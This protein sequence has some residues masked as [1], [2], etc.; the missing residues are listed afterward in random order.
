MFDIHRSRYTMGYANSAMVARGF[1][2]GKGLRS[3]TALF[4]RAN[5]FVFHS[6][7]SELL[8]GVI[9]DMGSA[10]DFI[11]DARCDQRLQYASVRLKIRLR[12]IN[13]DQYEQFCGDVF[14]VL[15]TYI[16]SITTLYVD[17]RFTRQQ[18]S[19]EAFLQSLNNFACMQQHL[20]SSMTDQRMEGEK[21]VPLCID[22]NINV[23]AMMYAL[24]R[25]CSE[26]EE[27]ESSE[28]KWP[29]FRAAAVLQD[30]INTLVAFLSSVSPPQCLKCDYMMMEILSNLRGCKCPF[31]S[32]KRRK[33][34][35]M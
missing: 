22:Y 13:I 33:F 10:L 23:H 24:R 30:A 3:T 15:R 7:N 18:L 26:A 9:Q 4:T 8:K 11:I 20:I 1:S 6:T 31:T 28:L 27:G 32:F 25:Y 17:V 16:Q 21:L 5:T 19:G 35:M 34:N 2:I 29:N 14:E 12:E